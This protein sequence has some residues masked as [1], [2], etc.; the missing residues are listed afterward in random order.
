MLY[1]DI[2]RSYVLVNSRH[3][4]KCGRCVENFDHHCIW[5]NNCV[6]SK[7]YCL[8]LAM[9]ALTFLSMLMFLISAGLLWG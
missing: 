9:I 2:C 3:C 8:F 1:C 5:V 7:N 4:K 6:G